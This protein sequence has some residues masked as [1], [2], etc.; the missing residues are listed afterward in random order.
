MNVI[1]RGVTSIKIRA[2]RFCYY[3]FIPLYTKWKEETIRKKNA[4]TIVFFATNLAMWRYQKVYELMSNDIHFKTVIVLSPTCTYP[5][6]QQISEISELREYFTKMKVPFV[7]WDFDKENSVL[8]VKHE[9]NPDII[10]FTQPY[11]RFQYSPHDYHNFIGKLFCYSQY[12]IGPFETNWFY[13]LEFH[14]I[15]WILFY[16]TNRDME[17]ARKLAWN[18]GKNVVI[19]GYTNVDYYNDPINIVPWKSIKG[20]LKRV[21]WA[22]HYTIPADN[23][24][25]SH[26]S[27]LW[28]AEPMIELTRKYKDQIQFAF[29]PHPKLRKELY[30]HPEWGKEKTDFYYS[31]WEKMENTQLETGD[32]IDLFKSSDAMIHDSSSFTLEYLYT[33]KPVMFTSKEINSIKK[34]FSP[35]GTLAIEQHYIGK[36]IHD[37]EQFIKDVVIDGKDTM[38]EQR[39]HFCFERLDISNGISVAN[40]ILSEIKKQ[41][42]II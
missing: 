2:K 30:L 29:K 34:S 37:I 5:K 11:E 3:H 19:T 31:K 27:F 14:N 17:C 15:A 20:K 8:D 23:T 4:I 6:E 16:A 22:P 42:N 10:F 35:F 24:M 18:K 12:G 38:R 1:Q 32:F 33:R 26:S 41:L 39:N 9:I 21:I 25:Y 36:S 13:N 28:L 7:D 40:N